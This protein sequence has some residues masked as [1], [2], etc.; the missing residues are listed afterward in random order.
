[1]AKHIHRY[2]SDNGEGGRL[3]YFGELW[4]NEGCAQQRVRTGVDYK[5]R[6]TIEAIAL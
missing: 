1:M 5:F 6:P 2:L 3:N 4:P